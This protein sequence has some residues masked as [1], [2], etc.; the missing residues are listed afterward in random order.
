MAHGSYEE[1]KKLVIKGLMVLGV[2]T[3]VEVC[4]ALLGNGHLIEGFHLPKWLMYPAMIGMSLY[5]AYFI[6][7]FFMHMAYEVQGLRWSVLLPTLLLVWAIIAFFQEGDSW[8]AR[9]EQIKQK[10]KE[11]VNA[12]P[13]TGSL[14]YDEETITT[15]L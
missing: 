8:G 2:I 4:I 6:V 9:R 14:D 1:Q 15:L 5:K 10:D 7:Y 3:I 12:K 11:E 13:S